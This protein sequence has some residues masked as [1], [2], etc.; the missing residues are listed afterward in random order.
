[1]E[2]NFMKEGNSGRYFIIDREPNSCKS[3]LNLFLRLQ[4]GKR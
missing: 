4:D 2:Y 1:M 3:L